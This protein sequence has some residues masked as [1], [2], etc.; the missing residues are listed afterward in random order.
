MATG[1]VRMFNEEK[2]Y[3]FIR[4]DAGPPDLFVHVSELSG[5]PPP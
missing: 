3:G 4:P 5:L 1:V 2:G